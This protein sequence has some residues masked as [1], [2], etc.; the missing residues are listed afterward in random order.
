MPYLLKSKSGRMAI[1]GS[2]FLS[3]LLSHLYEEECGFINFN[4]P[5]AKQLNNQ[6]IP[7]RVVQ[8]PR[9]HGFL[10]RPEC[11]CYTRYS[12]WTE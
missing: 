2:S 7:L 8:V 11:G 1:C 10:Y 3:I 6:H 5:V 9:K 12:R 4:K